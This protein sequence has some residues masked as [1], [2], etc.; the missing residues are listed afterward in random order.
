MTFL[1]PALLATIALVP[2]GLLIARRIDEGRRNRLAGLTG[3]SR[4]N[5]P[6][7][8]D[9]PRAGEAR[10]DGEAPA[11]KPGRRGIRA[12]E[13]VAGGLVVAAFVLFAI[14]LGRPQAT[15]SL[16]RVEGTLILT[17]DVSGSMAAV[18]EAPSRMDAAKAAAR[19]IVARQQ[20]GVVIGVVAFSDAGL[21]VQPPTA[22]Q[23]TVLAAI[24][25]LGPTRGTSLGEGILA[26]LTSIRDAESDTPPGYYSNRSSA[27][28][29]SPDPV[30]PG[31]HPDAAIILFSDGENNE[32]PDPIEAARVAADRG[33]RIL[34]VGV[35]TAAG[36]TLDLDGF[37]V[38][39]SLD[40]GALRAIADTTTGTYQPAAS[41]DPGVA[42][43]DLAE[44]LVTR[45]EDVEL[46]AIV[47][48]LGIALLLAGV[49]LSFVRSGRLP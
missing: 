5:A 35:G 8:A 30:A 45:N 34:T 39:T 17:F 24:E 12:T 27:P 13:R 15:V 3:R 11:T 40:E 4:L 37:R 18:D 44:H 9:A 23:A 33:I 7:A 21:S 25:R 10:P 46:T 28:T 32:R 36:T 29:E 49:G 31:S 19:A 16:P 6:V 1:W 2:V 42:Y 41:A 22:D 14:A 47:A 43:R 20:T 26:A 38:Q 48:G